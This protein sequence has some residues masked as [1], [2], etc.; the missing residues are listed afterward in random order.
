MARAKGYG[1]LFASALV[2]F[3]FLAPMGASQAATSAPRENLIPIRG[4]VT[5]NRAPKAKLTFT[6]SPPRCLRSCFMTLKATLEAPSELCIATAR[7][8]TEREG[9]RTESN[10]EGCEHKTE[11]ACTERRWSKTVFYALGKH[12]AGFELTSE[13]GTKAVASDVEFYVGVPDEEEAR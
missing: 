6:V 13:D 9:C 4:G 8:I 5:P 3:G 10:R 1:L 11:T 12:K 7:F 2:T